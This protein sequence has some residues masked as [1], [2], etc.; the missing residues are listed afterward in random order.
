MLV[1]NEWRLS[2]S[3]GWVLMTCAFL[4][5]LPA[6]NNLYRK[7]V[8]ISPVGDGRPVGWA[9]PGPVRSGPV[10]SCLIKISVKP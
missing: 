6:P 5:F 7:K 9:A 1:C 8:G 10:K 3:N 4:Y 2:K